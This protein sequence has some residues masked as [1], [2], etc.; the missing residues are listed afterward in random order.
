MLPPDAFASMGVVEM[1]AVVGYMEAIRNEM[2][3]IML[4]SNYIVAPR[5]ETHF[6]MILHSDVLVTCAVFRL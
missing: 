5:E 6:L 3:V 2:A 1:Q 4:L